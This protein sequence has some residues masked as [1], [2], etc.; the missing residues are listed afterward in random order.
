[1][2]TTA[3]RTA[4]RERIEADGEVD[5]ASLA[6]E[7]A[8]SEMTI[9]RDVGLLEIDGI[10]RRVLGGAIASPRGVEPAFSTR[11]IDAAAGKS[12]IATAV[13][14]RL[15]P[16]ETV[17]L[18]S[19]STVLAVARTIRGR[20]LA[21]RIITP[22]IL[23]AI[24]LAD[25]PGTDIV[26]TGG[27]VRPGELSLIGAEP[28]DAFA[29]Y[30]ANTYVMGAAGLDVRRGATDYSVDES[31]VKKAAMESAD[32]VV[33][34]VDRSKLGVVEYAAIAPPADLD[35]VVTDGSDADPTLAGLAALGVEIILA[36]GRLP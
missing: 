5:Y 6:A 32:R 26:L 28:E 20:D 16:Q 11:V 29:R 22:S 2:D 34:A 24:E 17:I 18:D 8:V 9:R 10:A 13:A 21:L 33:L 15:V 36:G 7:F 12:H 1:M 27:R 35:A 31:R 23:V 19:G 14:A 30:N 4:I 25:E 3:R